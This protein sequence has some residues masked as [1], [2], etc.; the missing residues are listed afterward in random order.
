MMY[1]LGKVLILERPQAWACF[2]MLPPETWP[3]LH[4]VSQYW[5][6]KVLQLV[7]TCY[8]HLAKSRHV[9]RASRTDRQGG[10]QDRINLPEERQR[11]FFIIWRNLCSTSTALHAHK[12]LWGPSSHTQSGGTHHYLLL[13]VIICECFATSS[14]RLHCCLSTKHTTSHF[15][16]HAF[17]PL[18]I[19]FNSYSS[20]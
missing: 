12:E 9:T 7:C 5:V 16:S 10:G 4:S 17:R 3:A 19:D 20:I 11:W 6:R 1:R 2:G 15:D 8:S 13:S 14:N 18:V